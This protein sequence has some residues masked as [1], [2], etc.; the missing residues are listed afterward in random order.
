MTKPKDIISKTNKLNVIFH[1]D[2]NTNHKGFRAEYEAVSSA[3]TPVNGGWSQWT[4]WSQ[5]SNRKDGKSVCKKRKVRYCN[6]PAP[7]NG[8]A[9]C[10]GKGEEFEDCVPAWT[11]PAKNP[12]CV[13]IG[14]WT[15][16]SSLSTCNA[17]CKATKERTCTNPKPLNS[18]ECEGEAKE[19][20]DCTGGSCASTSSGVIQ[21]T[22]YPANYPN[23]D[24]LRFPLVVAAGSTIQL[25][26]QDFSLEPGMDVYGNG[27]VYDFVQVLDSDGTTE[28]KKLCGGSGSGNGGGWSSNGGSGSGNGG[29][30]SGNGGS[31]YGNGSG[32]GGGWS[33]NGGSGSGNGNG[34]GGDGS[35]AD[36]IA[37]AIPSPIR[38][39]GNKMTVLFHSDDIINKKGFKASWKAVT[40]TSSGEVT[41][42]NYPAKYPHNHVETKIISVPA[43]MKIELTFTY[44]A[45]EYYQDGGQIYCSYDKLEIF[46]GDKPSDETKSHTLCGF[47]LKSLPNNPIISKGNTL[48]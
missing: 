11:D 9:N 1:S 25:T 38:S 4:S 21:S 43:G 7:A 33:S 22:N 47:E 17:Q 40:G 28:L 2:H 32:N 15:A 36:D 26:F 18:K 42:P 12:N 14:G 39:T 45:I 19:T 3:P 13:L 8:G 20:V 10:A 41:S 23:K 16:W 46:D 31:G 24:D 29:G 48:H 5:C 44:F 30:W 35:I 6:E 37:N 34:N 27:C